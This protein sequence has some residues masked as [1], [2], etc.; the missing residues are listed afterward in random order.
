MKY[1][2]VK[3]APDVLALFDGASCGQEALNKAGIEYRNYY[4]SEIDKYAK[5]V[6]QDNHPKTFQ[7]GDVTKWRHWGFD[8]S[9]IGI[10]F[11]G[12]PCQAWSVA[13]KQKGDND[14]RGALVHDLISIWK[15]VKKQNPNVKFLFENV[16]M[17]KDF[18][19]YINDLFGVEPIEINSSLVSGQNRK[20]LYWSNIDDITIPDDKGILLKDIIEDGFV[21][22]DK[23]YCLDANYFKGTNLEQYLKKCRRQ[24]VFNFSSSGRG[25]GVVENRF[26]NSGDKKAHCL[27][28]TGYSK[29]SF[30]GVYNKDGI[31][32]L[33]PIE[34]ERL[35]NLP[36]GYTSAVSNTQRYKM[37]GNGWT[38]DVIAHI[39]KGLKQ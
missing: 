38:V 25:N 34:C 1:L 36:D 8:F 23:S 3:D 11:A 13:G 5:I 35:Q 15:E 39:L 16:K 17:K 27:T 26:Y 4:A 21:D 28:K 14:P 18:I 19:E 37:I 24:I 22:R 10:I 9:K 6:A 30:T 2:R 32:K 33:T 20:R 7:L 29:R 31:R 12:F